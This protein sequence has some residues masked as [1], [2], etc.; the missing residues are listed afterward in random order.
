[1]DFENVASNDFAF[2]PICITD[3]INQTEPG[4][5]LC[6]TFNGTSSITCIKN[7]KLIHSFIGIDKN[8]AIKARKYLCEKNF[9]I[10]DFRISPNAFEASLKKPRPHTC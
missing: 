7:G 2:F 10:K 6:I 9:E 3:M 5:N 1:M 4:G 8:Y